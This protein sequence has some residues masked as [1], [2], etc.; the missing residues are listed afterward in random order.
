MCDVYFPPQRARLE[1]MGGGMLTGSFAKRLQDFHYRAAAAGAGLY[2]DEGGAPGEAGL[3]PGAGLG[4][5]PA[6]GAFSVAAKLGLKMPNLAPDVE[7]RRGV[8]WGRALCVCVCVCVWCF[9]ICA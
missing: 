6:G 5:L 7:V 3:H 8:G 4:G 9:Q 1:G 2:G